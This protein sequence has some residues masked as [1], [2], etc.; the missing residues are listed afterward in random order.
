MDGKLSGHD[1]KIGKRISQS[2][3]KDKAKIY[4]GWIAKWK[5]E[6]IKG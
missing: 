3:D 4:G 5:V 2:I 6:R 1:L